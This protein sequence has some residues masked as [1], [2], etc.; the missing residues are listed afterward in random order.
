MKRGWQDRNLKKL[1]DELRAMK[2]YF[3]NH[4]LI[5]FSDDRVGFIGSFTIDDKKKYFKVI[6]PHT[7]PRDNPY[8]FLLENKEDLDK[9]VEVD[10]EHQDKGNYSL[11]LYPSDDGAQSW[12][13]FYTAAD[14]IKKLKK[15]FES[16]E[17]PDSAIQEHTSEEYNFPGIPNDG[18][19]YMPDLILNE[20][21]KQDKTKGEIK[22]KYNKNV[23]WITKLKGKIATEDI[24]EKI[25]WNIMCSNVLET[26]KAQFLLV[27]ENYDE[28]KSVSYAFKNI[29]EF[30]EN[31]YDFKLSSEI[32]HLIIIFGDES[33]ALYSNE[34]EN[35]YKNLFRVKFYPGKV[36]KVPDSFFP[37]VSDFFQDVFKELRMK[38]VSII[39]LGSLGSTIAYQLV[40]T[41]VSCLELYDYDTLQPENISR[42]IGRISQLGQYKTE[43]IKSVLKEINPH[44]IVNAHSV[45][46]FSGESYEKLIQEIKRSDL[47]IVTS[48][49]LDSE[50][51]TNNLTTSYRI[52]TLFC[53]CS[54]EADYGEIFIYLPRD[55]ACYECFLIKKENGLIYNPKRKEDD[56]RWRIPGRE[57][58]NTPGIPGISIDIDFIG[59]FAS[60]L[61]LQVLMRDSK[62][63]SKYYP[64]LKANYYY[65][66]NQDENKDTIISFGPFSLQVDREKSCPTC[67]E[68]GRRMV[69]PIKKER[70]ELN[71]LI[72]EAKRREI[73]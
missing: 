71:H 26:R 41:G 20:I 69:T 33:F 67:S 63:F 28:F 31:F 4:Q 72:R 18:T 16:H 50:F 27:K 14:A 25:P 68:S 2:L 36:I 34:D 49:N 44:L 35:W 24:S 29:I 40:K 8:V 12:R 66:D 1:L 64:E 73:Q 43:V 30:L 56:P 19:I 53:W 62:H 65:W 9:K 59:L 10:S 5:N 23:F 48:A 32:D 3:P 21:T 57:P 47:V 42:H 38:E 7:Y 37:R 55:G 39:G 58:C 22:V 70:D 13:P 15:F 61:A 60:R 17:D 45:N 51:L 46:P 11:C 6:Y 54:G 52:P